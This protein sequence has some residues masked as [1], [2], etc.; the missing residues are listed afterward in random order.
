MDSAAPSLDFAVIGHQDSW[1]NIHSFV[2]SIR[3]PGQEDLSLENVK[4]IFPFIPARDLFRVKVKSTIGTEIHGVYIDTFI[5]PDK[6]DTQ[7]IRANIRK[8]QEAITHA[9]K[10]KPGIV[11]MGGFTSIVLEGNLGQYATH[12][13]KFTSGNTLTSAFIVKGV[14]AVA[15][16]YSLDLKNSSILVI[17]ATG[18]IG[19]ACVHYF[20]SKTKRLLLC[21][22]NQKRLKTFAHLLID[23]GKDIEY[24][25][26][27]SDI[28]PKADV[29][30]CVASSTG[31]KFSNC[32][33]HVI[34][35]DAGYPKNL[36]KDVEGNFNLI[37]HGGM[38]QVMG[39]Y[40]FKPD[41]TG[42]FYQYP[43]PYVIHGC[44]LEA[45]VLG[46]ENKFENYTQ[47]KGNITIEK[48][49]EVYAMAAKHGIV[50]APFYNNSGLC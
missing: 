34:I 8:V 20:K 47:G 14:E 9:K 44:I 10:F 32:K 26:S 28:M 2:N 22:R 18:D 1:T 30:I 11:A 15:S 38:G 40:E 42:S 46:F 45:M 41:Y 23:E 24:S 29:I 36:D 37:Y 13:S 3:K 7:N 19:Q 4:N 50:I 43:A 27:L 31:L 48:I 25:I 49:E 35:C 6:L 12:T 16:K 21:A 5:E 17:G 33:D 39:G